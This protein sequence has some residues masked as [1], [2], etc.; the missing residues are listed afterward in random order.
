MANTPVQQAEK[1]PGGRFLSAHGHSSISIAKLKPTSLAKSFGQSPAKT[2]SET[3]TVARAKTRSET[4]AKRKLLLNK[5]STPITCTVSSPSVLVS[6]SSP[7]V[8][9]FNTEVLQK[10]YILITGSHPRN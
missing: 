7:F 2:T 3:S 5:T 6:V 4:T 1:T 9:T 8:Q 10:F